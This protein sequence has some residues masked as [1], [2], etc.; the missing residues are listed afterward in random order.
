MT[1]NNPKYG[2]YFSWG[3]IIGHN[4]NGTS[5]GYSFDQANYNAGVCGSGHTL[6]NDI[7][8]G[9]VRYDGAAANMG[10]PWRMPTK[11]Q[12]QELINNTTPQWTSMNGV[13]GYKFTNKSNSSKYIFLPAAGY[14]RNTS[15]G[16]AGVAGIYL[17]TTWYSGS[18]SI[19]MS[20]NSSILNTGNS[21]RADGYSSHPIQ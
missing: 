7:T 1:L 21:Y 2:E 12:C 13:N 3:D 14:C 6:T 17:S 8:P 16:S 18:Q 9:D 19:Y 11:V 5:D 15:F 10:S 4:K 20:F